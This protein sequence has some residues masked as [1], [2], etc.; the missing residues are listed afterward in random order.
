MPDETT[1]AQVTRLQKEVHDLNLWVD[2]LQAGLYINCV[3][4]GHR[5]GPKDSFPPSMRDKLSEHIFE[6][7]KHP[8]SHLLTA[9]RNAAH[10]LSV[11]LNP[12][13]PAE[14]DRDSLLKTIQADCQTALRFCG[15]GEGV[16]PVDTARLTPG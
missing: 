8:A 7:A 16:N 2:D 1:S 5:F 13:A 15:K 4:C 11:I 12:D 10:V 9:C 6:C 3:Y 14:L